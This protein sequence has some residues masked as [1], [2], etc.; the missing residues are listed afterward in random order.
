MLQFNLI[1]FTIV[2]LGILWLSCSTPIYKEVYPTLLD[3]K[4]DSEFPYHG[5]SDQLEQIAESVRMISCIAYY[6]SYVFS[7]EARIRLNDIHN[8]FLMN[9]VTKIQ[10]LNRTA[11]GTATVIYFEDKCVALLTCAH[12]IEFPDTIF[13][14]YRDENQKRSEFI[15]SMAIKERQSNYAA[16]VSG[17]RDLSILAIDKENDLVLLGQKLDVQLPFSIP[18]FSYPIGRAKELE[19]GAFVYLFGY[20]SGYRLI[21]KGI[22]SSP[23]RDQYGSFLTDAVCSKGFSGG[24]VLAIRDGIPNFE[25]IGMLKLIPGRQQ[26]YL[27]PNKEGDIADFEPDVAYKGDM[28]VENRTDITYGVAPA[29]PAELIVEFLQK[30]REM[31]F[32]KGYNMRSFIERRPISK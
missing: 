21:T 27:V 28:Y 31:L 8:I 14:Y 11:S 1:R 19:W 30:N 23:N 13:T 17:A 32:D 3:G 4:Y 12:I 29:I 25:L 18:V 20:P 22:V 2:F 7:Q 24:I 15:H 9:D 6:K 5:C 26:F 10:Y 16:A